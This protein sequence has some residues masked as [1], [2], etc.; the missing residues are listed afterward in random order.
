[1]EKLKE[2]KELS[3]SE[4]DKTAGWKETSNFRRFY[5]MPI[6]KTSEDFLIQWHVMVSHTWCRYLI[7]I[8]V[9]FG[10]FSVFSLTTLLFVNYVA[11]KTVYFEMDWLRYCEGKFPNHTSTVYDGCLWFSWTGQAMISYLTQAMRSNMP[12]PTLWNVIPSTSH[13][14][15]SQNW[16]IFPPLK[17]SR[18]LFLMAWVR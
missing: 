17:K 1:M 5:D 11:L 15:I 9:T 7:Y 12:H 16:Q 3:L 10:K 2:I 6:Y 14:K 18:M 8:M 4:I 13:P